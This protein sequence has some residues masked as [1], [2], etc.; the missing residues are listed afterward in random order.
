MSWQTVQAVLSIVGG[1]GGLLGAWSL[2]RSYWM[3]R[4]RLQIS[5]KEDPDYNF[6]ERRG[7]FDGLLITILIANK[8]SQPNSI[9]KYQAQATLREGG[10]RLSEVRQGTT[11]YRQGD[12]IL[13]EHQTCVIPLNLPPHT[14]TEA[15]LDFLIHAPDFGNPLQ[16][17]ITATDMHGNAY[18]VS[19]SVPNVF[20]IRF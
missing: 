4:P 9:L 12:R 2:I 17:T 1:I 10:T 5:Q 14:T 20:A 16:A 19:C 8:S 11:T 13:A 15:F 18:A 6:I 3:A 7:Q